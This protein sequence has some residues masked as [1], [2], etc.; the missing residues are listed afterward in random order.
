MA[1]RRERPQRM[2]G[3][4]A[5][6]DQPDPATVKATMAGAQG[7]CMPPYTAWSRRRSQ[8]VQATDAIDPYPL[9]SPVRN[10]GAPVVL[11]CG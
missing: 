4:N 6:D 7:P 9:G 10:R 2:K 8:S 1:Q 5:A 3:S 11:R